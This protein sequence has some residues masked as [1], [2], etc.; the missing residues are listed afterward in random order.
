MGPTGAEHGLTDRRPAYDHTVMPTTPIVSVVV[1]V[2]NALPDLRQCMFSV[3]SQD[4]GAKRYEVLAVDDGS[5]D[6]SSEILAEYERRY[7]GLLRVISQEHSG[8]PGRPRNAG[9]DA[10]RG[11]YVFF[12]DADD[13]IR[14]QSLR[15]QVGFADEHGCDIVVPT[16]LGVGDRLVHSTVW[17]HTEVD[18]DR[19][20]LFKTLTPH[21]LFRRGFL[22]EHE[23][24]FP[25]GRV[26]LEDG[27]FL[28]RAYLLAKRV[29]ILADYDHYR[30]RLRSGGGNISM[31]RKPPAEFTS[32]VRQILAI[33]RELAPDAATA[34]AIALDLLSRKSLKYLGPGRFPNYRASTRGDWVEHIGALVRASIPVELESALPMDKRLLSAAVRTGD[35]DSVL[36]VSL[37]VGA[38]GV[39]ARLEGGAMLVSLPG[40]TDGKSLDVTGAV[41]VTADLDEIRRRKGRLEIA[42][43]VASPGLVL[44]ASTAGVLARPEAGGLD[45]DLADQTVTVDQLGT[46]ASWSLAPVA[47]RRLEP[48]RYAVLVTLGA[49][50]GRPAGSAALRAGEGIEPAMPSLAYGLRVVVPYLTAEQELCLRVRRARVG[51]V[52]TR[53]QARSLLRRLARG[54][55]ARP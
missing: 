53:R 13:E 43:R 26:P 42:A 40:R 6:G 15:R 34:D 12:L 28:A 46:P 48:G 41:E 25:E 14:R 33:V 51:E 36:A 23:L 24:R 22:D 11:R 20:L 47:V 38:G 2:F 54:L 29:S 52:L 4:L 27:L 35:V 8:W 7:P 55:P 49:P 3:L 21:K 37:A 39:P 31:A 18:A 45:V 10:S 50:A 16:L 19:S 32:S 5:T 1:P 9:I 30:L 17:E 44:G